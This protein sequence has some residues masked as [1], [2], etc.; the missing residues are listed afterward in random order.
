MESNCFDNG[1]CWCE[2]VWKGSTDSQRWLGRLLDNCFFG[3]TPR[4]A[5]RSQF[6]KL[7]ML[8]NIQVV[9]LLYAALN[10]VSVVA[11]VRGHTHELN[12]AQATKALKYK[13]L[14][15]PWGIMSTT[16]PKLAVACLLERLLNPKGM[17]RLQKR[18][19]FSLSISCN[20]AAVLCAIFSFIR[21]TPVAGL[22]DLQ[23]KPTC[24]NV[25]TYIGF[26][27]FTSGKT[28]IVGRK[29]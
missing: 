6:Q 12:L 1:S 24:W 29:L 18:I 16:V 3:E 15:N 21:C 17:N 10:T 19:W 27:I 22:W 8:I 2:A 26:A 11:A 9:N 14:A 7:T 20:L 25:N 13:S 5:L 23:V 4:M 28:P